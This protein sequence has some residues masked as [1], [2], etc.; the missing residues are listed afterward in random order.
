MPGAAR[1]LVI[2]LLPALLAGS[3]HPGVAAPRKKRTRSK[4]PA[5]TTAKPAEK[6]FSVAI[7]PPASPMVPA[8]D[9]LHGQVVEDPYRWLEDDDSPETRRWVD[10]QNNYTSAMLSA[11]P[12][13]EAIRS[14]LSALLRIG[15]IEAPTPRGGRYFYQRRE[16]DQ[17]QPVLYVRDGQTGAPRVLID[18]NKLSSDGTTALDWWYPSPDGKLLAYG[19][20]E[21]GNEWSTLRIRDVSTGADLPHVIPNTR[22]AS[23][24]WEPGNTGFYYTRY[25]EKGA[26]P[27]G[28]EQ[29]NRRVF[30]HALSGS[31]TPD[32][33]VFGDGRDREDWPSIDLS[34]NGR[35]LVAT[36]SVGWSRTDVYVRDLMRPDAAWTTVVEKTDALFS[37][38]TVGD[39]LYV[40]TNWKAPRFHVFK[41]SATTPTPEHWRE[42]IPQSAD[43]LQSVSFVGGKLFALYLRNAASQIKVFSAEG[44]FE[45]DLELPALGTAGVVIGEPDGTEAFFSYSSFFIPPTVYRYDIG[46]GR[47][48]KHDQVAS[49]IDSSPYEVEQVW[50]MS[51]DR[52]YVSM[53]LAHRKGLKLNGQN[54]TLLTGYGGFNVAVTPTF[55]R[56]SFLWLERGGVLAVANLRGGSEYGESWHQAGMLERKQNVF[57]DFIAAAEFL[58]SRKYTS[59]RRLCI[60]GGSN[61]GLLVGAA[62]VQ[63]PDLF[64]AVVCQVPLLDMIR[65]HHFLIASLWIPEYGSSDDPAQFPYLLRYSPYHNVKKGTPYPVVLIDTAESD[66]RVAPLHARKMTARLQEASTSGLPILLRLETRAG[67]GQGKPVTKLIEQYTDIWSFIFMQLGVSV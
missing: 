6:T 63:R 32:S 45:R 26:V 16:G 23:V 4:P 20:S 56:N 3:V 43:V 58:I 13:R 39:T 15:L 40:T 38:E 44:V 62:L 21:S 30:H 59:P 25:P 46:A 19:T 42:I 33:L 55:Q 36:V 66:S 34:R 64:S 7:L 47:L 10:A 9:T 48:G 11:F 50:Y 17:D 61:G 31:G 54:P 60:Q 49:G 5:S 22:A 18:P 8:A 37:V 41:V 14:R 65:Y 12:G 51:K 27:A 53:F 29:Y 57:D 24:A 52:T 2:L 35:W 1:A 28:E 67:H